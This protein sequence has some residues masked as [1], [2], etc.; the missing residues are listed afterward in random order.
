MIKKPGESYWGGDAVVCADPVGIDRGRCG[1]PAQYDCIHR[2]V[3]L[4]GLVEIRLC[5]VPAP[6]AGPVFPLFL[7]RNQH[8]LPVTPIEAT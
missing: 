7:C 5:T 1:E 2:P 3:D 8:S 6:G 4:V